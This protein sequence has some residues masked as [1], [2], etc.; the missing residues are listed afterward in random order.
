MNQIRLPDVLSLENTEELWRSL[1]RP[2]R[3][4]GPQGVPQ[5]KLDVH[6][7]DA[8]YTV[9]AEMPGVKKEDIDVRIEGAQVSISAEVKKSDEKKEGTRVLRAERYEGFVSRSFTLGC[10][11][12]RDKVSARYQDGVLELRLPKKQSG[13]AHKVT[14]E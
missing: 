13:A 6:E 2:L 5:I 12:D 4:D 10:E 14:I 3:W 11:I 8:A 9:K 7:D 1:L